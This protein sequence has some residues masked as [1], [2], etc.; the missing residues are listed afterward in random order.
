[1]PGFKKQDMVNWFSPKSLVKIALETVLSAVF[2]RYADRREIQAA[3]TEDAQVFSYAEKEEIWFDY[4]ADLGDGFNPTYTVATALAHNELTVEGKPLQRGRFLVMGGDQVYPSASTELY[5]NRLRGP[6]KHA[7]PRSE[8]QSEDDP[9]LY[10][11]PGNHDWYDGLTAFLRQF[12]QGRY[13]GGWRT[14]QQRSYFAIELPHNWWLLAIDIQLGAD[15]DWP[16]KDYFRQAMK[17]LSADNKVIIASAEPVWIEEGLT[18]EKVASSLHYIEAQVKKTGAEVAINLAG[19]LHHYA[20]YE[21]TSRHLVTCGGGGAFAHGTHHLSD[22]LTLEEKPDANSTQQQTAYSLNDRCF[23]SK[24]DSIKTLCGNLLFFMK[25]K[26]MAATIGF[27]YTLL[28]LT[29]QQQSLGL[30]TDFFS[31]IGNEIVFADFL[32]VDLFQN[33]PGL[34]LMLLFVVSMMA[35][36]DGFPGRS[37]TTARLQRIF[38]GGG[39]GF[40]HILLALYLAF[41]IFPL[42]YQSTLISGFIAISVYWF[43]ASVSAGLLFGLYLLFSNLLFKAHGDA[44]MS[45]NSIE[46]YKSFLRFHLNADGELTVYAIGFKKIIRNWFLNENELY[47]SSANINDHAHIIDRFSIAPPSNSSLEKIQNK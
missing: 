27:L 37:E 40:L 17:K 30:F 16:Q 32:S 22:N 44:A 35:F 28:I 10:A 31:Q 36:Y 29:Y 4:V 2:G 5:N 26:A 41:L 33:M 20:H 45:S 39:H 15:L 42:I 23:P 9:H 25:N 7:L 8:K 24:S 19:D 38:I 12:V 13:I 3:L 1:M 18:G 21:S 14:Q 6:Y 47:R 46:D 34:L 43:V 11:L